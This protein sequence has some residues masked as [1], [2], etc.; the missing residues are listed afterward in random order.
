VT[1]E[2]IGTRVTRKTIPLLHDMIER[3]ET[4]H[5]L[6]YDSGCRC[7]TSRFKYLHMVAHGTRDRDGRLEYIRAPFRT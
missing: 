3:H 4:R 6:E 5:R 2:L 1:L 7:P